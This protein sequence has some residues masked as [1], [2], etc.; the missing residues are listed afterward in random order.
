MDDRREWIDAGKWYDN[1]YYEFVISDY[2]QLFDGL[3]N[4]SQF[5]YEYGFSLN[6]MNYFDKS[7]S[8]LMMGAKISS[9]PMFWNVMGN[10]SL[11]QGRYREAEE[12]YK[13]AFYMVPNRLYPLTLLA[14][15]YH[16]E[17]DTVSFLDMADKVD[18]FVPKIENNITEIL[19]AEIRE[20]REGYNIEAIKNE[21]Q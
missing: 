21:E 2:S 14:K 9:N 17:G 11:A 20:I 18:S 4:N 16:T 10:N 19:R 13:H 8:I 7:D 5:L 1:E 12:R 3:K 6:K 15:L